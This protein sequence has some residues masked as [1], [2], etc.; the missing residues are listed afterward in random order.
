[1]Y[2]VCC[3]LL[4]KD[5]VN[6]VDKHAVLE[7]LT[8][9]LN[10]GNNVCAAGSHVDQVTAGTVGELDGVDSSGRSNNVGNVGDGCSRGGTKVQ[11]LSTGLDV[12]GL[13]TTQDTGSQLGS[14]RVPDTVLGLGGGAVLALS[15]LD[16][17]AL[18]VVDALA[19]GKVGRGQQVFL[20]AANDEDALV[21]VGFLKKS[22]EHIIKQK[23]IW[24]RCG[25]DVLDVRRSSSCRPWHHQ[26]HRRDLHVLHEVGHHGLC[27]WELHGHL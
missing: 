25:S 13:E 1:M 19:G 12:D 6:H 9:I 15:I 21:S 7:R 3:N 5:E 10:D 16:R 26:V 22:Y 17:N 27:P 11:G 14:K 18:L 20:A 24:H 23:D 8:G 2:D 4:S